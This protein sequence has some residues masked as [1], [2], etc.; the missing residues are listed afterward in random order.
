[1]A[2]WLVFLVSAAVIIAAG[3]RLARDADTIAYRTGLGR[4]WIGM[5][6]VAFAT[7]LPEL[8]TDLYAIRQHTPE[9]AIGDLFG[10]SMTNMLVLAIGDLLTLQSRVATRVNVNQALTAIAVAGMLVDPGATI[11]GAGWASLAIGAGYIGGMWLLY[12]NRRE[13]PF[14][15]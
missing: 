7:S 11:L 14:L 13:P 10:S 6:L 1:M 4:A 3:T 2:P 8:T 5:I 15:K 12:A 9:L